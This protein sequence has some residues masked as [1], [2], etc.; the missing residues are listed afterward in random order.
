MADKS[1]LEGIR[2]DVVDAILVNGKHSIVKAHLELF[3]EVGI[4]SAPEMQKASTHRADPAPNHPAN[5]RLG[6]GDC[7]PGTGSGPEAAQPDERPV[8][9]SDQLWKPPEQDTPPSESR[10]NRRRLYHDYQQHHAACHQTL[11]RS[12]VDGESSRLFRRDGRN[13]SR[14]GYPRFLFQ[15]SGGQP[16]PE[17]CSGVR[18]LDQQ[19]RS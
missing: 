18:P 15:L 19:E 11:L 16:A 5:R 12:S 4:D 2:D 17:N 3:R 10:R 13:G 9:E 1:S 7:R 14:S 6:R 8:G